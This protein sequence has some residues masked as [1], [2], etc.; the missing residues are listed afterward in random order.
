MRQEKEKEAE[1]APYDGRELPEDLRQLKAHFGGRL[2]RKS[3]EMEDFMENGFRQFLLITPG[4]HKK[5]GYCTYCRKKVDLSRMEGV[6]GQ[7]KH[8]D[9]ITCPRC[10]HEV[11][12][13]TH[14]RYDE[15]EIFFY[16]WEKSAINPMAI[17]CRGIHAMRRRERENMK[18]AYTQWDTDSASVFI[19]GKGSAMAYTI[20]DKWDDKKRRY[21]LKY[22]MGKVHGR[23]GQ[24]SGGINWWVPRGKACLW[25]E[26]SFRWAREGT[27][28]EWIEGF[29]KHIKE[30]QVEGAQVWDLVDGELISMAMFCKY[31]AWEWIM[32]MGLTNILE[33]YATRR[34]PTV[35][36][37]FN[38]RGKT[39]DKIFRGHLTKE[40]KEYLYHEGLENTG[41]LE[42]WQTW[43]KRWPTTTLKEV[44]QL[45]RCM[46]NEMGYGWIQKR[47][48][49]MFL[50]IRPDRLLRYA[51]K[52][53]D[54]KQKVDLRDY[55]DYLDECRELGKNL[56]DRDVLFPTDFRKAHEHEARELVALKNFEKQEK[57]DKRRTACAARYRFGDKDGRY[58][59]V[60]PEKLEDLVTEGEHMHNCVGTY[61]DRLA[62]GGSDILFVR[63]AD[64]PEES[65]ITVEVDPKNGRIRQAR[66]KYNHDIEDPAAKD[67][68]KALEQHTRR[69]AARA[70]RENAG[71]ISIEH[72]GEQCEG[73]RMA[74]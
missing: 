62:D 45:D 12:V 43:K 70:A 36:D 17:V 28:F 71:N 23:T 47:V 16:W 46:G 6:S 8:N 66:E 9:T 69:E 50:F 40:D 27:P 48:Q 37:V 19:Y 44:I 18:K 2:N 57:W 13:I 39:V 38:F 34:D 53:E 65:Y 29:G 15:Q 14:K 68:I 42:A 72:K 59:V 73:R 30:R 64:H 60:L 61:I 35:W 58:L 5:E 10:G 51:L 7:M 74:L 52:E 25:A 33:D 31:R 26:D 20:K 55:L 54:G 49:Q 3:R 1:K 67:F 24:Y 22:R 11:T 63:K 21:I 41:P 56:S 32:K 4:T